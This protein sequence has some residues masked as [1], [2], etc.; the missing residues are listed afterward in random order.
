MALMERLM[1]G[2]MRSK[3]TRGNSYICLNNQ[4][5][6][7]AKIVSARLYKHK[8][9]ML[10]YKPP[11]SPDVNIQELFWHHIRTNFFKQPSIQDDTPTCNTIALVREEVNSR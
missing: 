10:F 9:M 1:S 11:R 4:R 5:T 3:F 7:L 8:L 6:H 2:K